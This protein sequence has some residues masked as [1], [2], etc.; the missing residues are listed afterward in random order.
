MIMRLDF[1]SK[2]LSDVSSCVDEVSKKLKQISVSDLNQVYQKTATSVCGRCGLKALCWQQEYSNTMNA[3]NDLTQALKGKHKITQEDFPQHFRERCNRLSE[4]VGAVNRYYTGYQANAAADRRISEVRGVVYDQFC[5]MSE[6]LEDMAQE[7][8]L[9]EKYDF[10]L[11]EQLSTMLRASG[12]LPIDV[13]CRVDRYNRLS[14]EIEAAK[15]EAAT[16]FKKDLLRQIDRVCGRKMDAP[17]IS[18]APDRCRIQFSEKPAFQAELAIAQHVCNN[19]SLCGDHCTYFNDGLGRMV[20][21]VSDGMGSGGR[22]A[23]D[24]A[25]AAGILAK[26]AKAGISFDCALRIVNSALLVKSGDESLATLDVARVD[27]FSGKAEFCKAG[28]AVSYVVRKGKIHRVDLP[29]LPAGILTEISFAKE[30]YQLQEGDRLLMISDGVLTEG[31]AWLEG[32]LLTWEDQGE[33][34]FAQRIVELA[35]EKRKDGHDDDITVLAA[36]IQIL[37]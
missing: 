14:V 17:C 5:G 20:M 26:L 4:V 12:V 29:S 25:M 9:Y 3:F 16:L 32:E 6:I 19:G 7:L 27:L 36:T 15:E 34:E 8:E 28:A 1:A 37:P 23:V 30:T 24:G 11:G 31:D 35:R 18:T 2:T 10:A 33:E 22:A 21:I 13:S